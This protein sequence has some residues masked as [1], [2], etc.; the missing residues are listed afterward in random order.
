MLGMKPWQGKTALV[1]GASSGIGRATALRL[2]REGL[3][4]VACA[5]RAAELDALAAEAKGASG[6]MLARTCDMRSEADLLALFSAARERFGGVDVLVNNAGL[7]HD[8]PLTSGSTEHWRDMLEVNV[9]ALC[10][11]TREAIADMRRRGDSGYV[12]H[13]S[14][15]AAHRVPRGSGVYAA[16]K[17]AVRALTEALRMELHAAESGIRVTSISPGFVETGFAALYHRDAGA[18]DATYGRYPCIQPDEIADAVVYVLSQAPHVQVHDI[19]MR[20]TRQEN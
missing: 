7:G 18:A 1:T 15:M 19:L 5:R 16:T 9:L 4:V 10:I 12:I 13:V 2:A 17:H 14:S 6:A 3:N 8:A 20:P 11:A